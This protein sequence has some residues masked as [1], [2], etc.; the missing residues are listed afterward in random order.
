M[1]LALRIRSQSNFWCGLLFVAIGVAIMVL[2]R[3]YRVGTAARMGPGYF[4][5]LLGMLLAGL[6]LTLTIPALFVDGEEFPRLHIRPLVM[7]LLSIVAFGVALEYHGFVVAVV[8]L[9]IIG[10]LA[11]PDLRPLESAALALFL[12]IFSVGIFVVL[13]GLPLTLWPVL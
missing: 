10:G 11:D 2:A 6:G 13:L 7:I 3:E 9:V 4:P 8:A 1:G 5:E 12:V